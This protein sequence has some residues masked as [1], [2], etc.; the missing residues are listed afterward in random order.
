MNTEQL[1]FPIRVVRLLAVLLTLALSLAVLAPP[2]VAQDGASD[3][4]FERVGTLELGDGMV[5]SALLDPSGEHAYF[6]LFT[7][8]GF[9]G[10][11]VKVRLRDF[12]QV[13]ELPLPDQRWWTVLAGANPADGFA[14]LATPHLSGSSTVAGI[15]RFD[16]GS[17]TLDDEE[18]P[19]TGEERNVA[20]AVLDPEGRFAYFGTSGMPD[21]A[22]V[23]KV[24]LETF[25]RVGARKLDHH[26]VYSLLMDPA[27]EYV[28]AGVHNGGIPGTDIWLYPGRLAKI[29]LATF[30]VVDQIELPAWRQPRRGVIDAAGEF[31]YFATDEDPARLLKIDL[32]RFEQVGEPLTF[33]SGERWPRSLASDTTGQFAYLALESPVRL[34]RIDLGTFTRDRALA[35]EP[36]DGNRASSLIVDEAGAFAY[37]GTYTAASSSGP[38]SS[39]V[40]KIAIGAYTFDGFSAPVE[41]LPTVNRATAGRTIPLKWRLLDPHGDP[42]TDLTTA[43]VAT[44]KATV[45]GGTT[46][47]PV[48]EYAAGKSG[49]QHLGD[50]YYQFNWAAPK[51]YAGSAYT[52]TLDLGTAG[53]HQALFQFTR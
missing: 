6:S 4:P 34:V 39:R 19:L 51:S 7:S 22:W 43:S 18:I 29:D 11:I 36:S 17:F 31:A 15:L 25:T 53:T 26:N 30:Q 23:I 48:E 3:R 20:S 14:Y 13:G 1:R 27:G 12:T 5:T 50:G 10:R 44:T 32:E 49:L 21:M 28:Y 46:V 41:N 9:E 8:P 16:L 45:A 52:V 2:G 24:D 42:V 38:Y 40:V 35:L 47:D 37:V 33:A